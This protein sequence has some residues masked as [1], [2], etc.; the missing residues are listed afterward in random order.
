[1]QAC[2]IVLSSKCAK[3]VI[4]VAR[5]RNDLS[6]TRRNSSG[7]DVMEVHFISLLN[8]EEGEAVT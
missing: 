1:M 8:G 6:K 3:E 7:N 5:S 4:R 2:R